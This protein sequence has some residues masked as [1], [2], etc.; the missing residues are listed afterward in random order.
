MRVTVV[1]PAY[2]EASRIAACLAALEQQRTS[3][4]VVVIVV[5][6]GST[7]ETANVVLS[8][9]GRLPIRLLYEPKKGRG[10]A[11]RKGFSN[12]RTRI[13]LST[14]AD[15]VV[16]PDW[17]DSLVEYLIQ[18]PKSAAITTSCYITDGTPLTNLTMWFGMP[19]S[20]RLYRL[21]SGHYLLSG[22]TFAVRLTAYRA[23]GG[24]DPSLDDL[25]DVDLAMR[26]SSVG[27]IG[28]MPKPRVRTAGDI[29]AAGYIQGFLHYFVP[30]VRRYV[31]PKFRAR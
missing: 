12:C 27:P 26:L 8:G 15:T 10:A 14:D 23:A 7:D 4:A 22:S 3:H 6:N 2:N 5:D 13:V 25:E 17:V 9:N 21:F 20:L 1:I 29:F 11:R 28:Y 18:H 31:V 24:F 16:P 19:I 30:F